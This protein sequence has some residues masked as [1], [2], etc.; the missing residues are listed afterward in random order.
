[1]KAVVC[2]EYGPIANLKLD[3]VADPQAIG[4]NVVIKA[5]AIGVNYPDG[6]LVQ[7]LYQ[8]R[9]ET[10][11][12]PGMEM[13][14]VVESVGPDVKK[15]KPGM[16]VVAL[17]QLGAFAE[18]GLYPEMACAPL[19][20]GMSEADACALMCGYGTSHHALKQRGNLQPGETLLV[21]GAAGATG[22]AAVQIGK[23]MGA[24]VIAIASSAEKQAAAKEAGADHVIGYDNLKDDVR[25]ITGKNGVDVIFDPVGGDAFDTMVRLMARNGRYLVIGFAAGR[26][27]ELP[28]NLAL[29]KEF[30]LV[31][32]FWGSFTRHEPSVYAE[33]VRELFGWYMDGKVK[34]LIGGEYS[35]AEA[36]DVLQKLMDRGVA[37][38]IV[39]KP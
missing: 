4:S 38:K 25:A 31:G 29:V 28:V 39:L 11:F 7:G 32:V 34:P 3:E 1:M 22:I 26:I 30:S 21:A 24:T 33:N 36:P 37:G 12:T 17:N 19:P 35:L 15:L 10:P 2:H 13:A 6:L 18:K 20:D 27:P 9:P 8:A 16:R 23:A 14:G 5:S